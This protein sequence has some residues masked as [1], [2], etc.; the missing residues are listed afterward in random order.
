VDNHLPHLTVAQTLDF[1]AETRVP[2]TRIAGASRSD[3]AHN[4]RD[5]LATTFGL[6]AVLQTIVG[7]DFIRGVSGG[8]RKRVSISEML[9]TRASVGL[10]DTPTRG[11]DASTSLE[12]AQ[13]LRVATSTLRTIA[14]A[15]LFQASDNIVNVFD[16]VTVLYAGRQVF[17]GSIPDALE[18][19]HQLGF[20][21]PTRQTTADFLTAVTDPNARVVRDG[22]EETAPR[23]ADQFAKRWQD[24]VYYRKLQAE[25]SEHKAQFPSNNPVGKEGFAMVLKT[26]QAPGLRSGSKYTLNIAMQMYVQPHCPKLC[27]D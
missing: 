9:A 18:H 12:Y 16:N 10:W 15:S 8:E 19:F 25:I 26:S 27:S 24:S 2:H 17:F 7:D 21:H 6:T 14:I 5:L 13:A 22:F 3:Y 11:L 1:A 4:T 20:F 23:N